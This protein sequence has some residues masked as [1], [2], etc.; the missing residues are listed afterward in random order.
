ME[1]DPTRIPD[2]AIVVRRVPPLFYP[3]AGEDQPSSG[4]FSDSSDGTGMSV[5]L[6]TGS[7]K[8]YAQANPDQAFVLLRVGDLRKIGLEIERQPVPGNDDHCGVVG[9]KRAKVKKNIK[10]IAQWGISPKELSGD[11]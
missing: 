5:D 10:A 4:A 11:P 2:D 7:V 9:K 3:K 6:L 8:E 1:G